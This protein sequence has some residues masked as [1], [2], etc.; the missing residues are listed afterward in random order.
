MFTVMTSI[1]TIDKLSNPS[2]RH[3]FNNILFTKMALLSII[4]WI[5]KFKSMAKIWNQH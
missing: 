3:L 4:K 5:K 1:K 2:L